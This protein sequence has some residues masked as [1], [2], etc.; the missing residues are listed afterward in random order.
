MDIMHL[1]WLGVDKNQR[2]SEVLARA[3][4]G[5]TGKES[6]HE[7]QEKMRGMAGAGRG[8]RFCDRVWW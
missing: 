2:G 4:D 3:T 7:T 6:A 1:L 8:L 5:H